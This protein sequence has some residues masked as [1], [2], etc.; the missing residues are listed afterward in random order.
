MKVINR[1]WLLILLVGFV[2]TS[3]YAQWPF[4][5][6]VKIDAGIHVKFRVRSLNH[7]DVKTLAPW[8]TYF[9][10]DGVNQT[11]G[12]LKPRFP[13]WQQSST[14]PNRQPANTNPLT[15]KMP[16]T[17]K[18]PPNEPPLLPSAP[19]TNPIQ[20]TA[21]QPYAYGVYTQPRTQS[22]RPVAYYQQAPSY[23][24]GR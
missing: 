21:Y 1:A 19:K 3:A 23:W 22:R 4:R 20:P 2:P 11:P 18:T 15:P 6:P 8:Y 14:N 10:Y 5:H 16:P 12:P 24:Y 7:H 13:N 9:P 17:L